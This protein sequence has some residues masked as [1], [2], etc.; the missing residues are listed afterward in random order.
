[1][2]EIDLKNYVSENF[3]S[4]EKIVEIV[5][6]LKDQKKKIGLCAGSF[7]LLHPGHITHLSSAKKFCDVLIVAIAK[8]KYSSGKYLKNGRPLFSDNIRAFMVSK[9]KPVDFVFLEEGVPETVIKIKPDV[10]I[11]GL[12]YSDEKDPDILLQKTMLKS[13]GGKLVFTEDEKQSTTEIIKYIKE[14]IK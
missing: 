1:M 11:K 2:I 3:V 9:L 12:D 8:D 10:Y 7:D 13:W 14:Q 5:K 4:E 6:N